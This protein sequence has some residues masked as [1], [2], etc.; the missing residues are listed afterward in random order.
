[1]LEERRAGVASPDD[2][3]VRFFDAGDR[4]K[5]EYRCSE[6]GYGVAVWTQLPTCPMCGGETWEQTGW[7][8]FSRARDRL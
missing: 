1:M 7:S 4:V 2:E 3:F 8:P 6:C 5:G